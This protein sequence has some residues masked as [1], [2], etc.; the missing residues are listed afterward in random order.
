MNTAGADPVP[1]GVT[2][3]DYGGGIGSKFTLGSSGLWYAKASV[4]VQSSATAGEFS[5]NIRYGPPLPSTSYDTV[6]DA[7]GGRREGL[8]RTLHPGGIRY[9]AVGTRLVVHLFNGT[10]SSRTL[11][12]NSGDW[13]QIDIWRVG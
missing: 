5:A 13:V 8:A 11:E 6:L 7:D 9:L 12:P 10:G 2:N 4:R 3:E 1:V